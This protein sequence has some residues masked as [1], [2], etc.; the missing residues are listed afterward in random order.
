MFT[1]HSRARFD[2]KAKVCQ[3]QKVLT[4]HDSD[5]YLTAAV[6]VKTFVFQTSA[7]PILKSSF[8]YM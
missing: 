4:S 1:W 7:I 6:F 3:L 5:S 8:K 2:I